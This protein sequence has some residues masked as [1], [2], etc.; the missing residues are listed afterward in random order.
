MAL[1]KI[2]L[3]AVGLSEEAPATAVY[4]NLFQ[5]TFH[6][7]LRQSS[8]S[9]SEWQHLFFTFH[10]YVIWYDDQN[11]TSS[12][13]L[14]ECLRDDVRESVAVSRDRI[15]N[16]QD[17]KV[18]LQ[19]YVKQWNEFYIVSLYAHLPFQSVDVNLL[20][21]PE[22]AASKNDEAGPIR[23]MM[24]TVWNELVLTPFAHR[25]LKIVSDIL[26]AER[27]DGL[28]Y[29]DLVLGV[30]DSFFYVSPSRSFFEDHYEQVGWISISKVMWG[31][32]VLAPP[33]HTGTLF[34]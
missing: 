27:D 14:Y 24:L 33:P 7:I 16:E 19:K 21:L 3:A 11:H 5:P 17:D 23:R 13:Q 15:S 9:K 12:V 30:R 10:Q 32:A 31:A 26:I 2:N 6:R 1:N 8:V 25:L 4:A 18:F 34:W 29:G 22:Y 20:E 28:L